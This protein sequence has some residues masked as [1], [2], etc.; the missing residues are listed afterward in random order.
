M[1]GCQFDGKLT[2]CEGQDGTQD[3]GGESLL[4]MLKQPR[5]A[6]MLLAMTLAWTILPMGYVGLTLIAGPVR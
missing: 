4:A 6:V 1:N 2:Q 5:L 3:E